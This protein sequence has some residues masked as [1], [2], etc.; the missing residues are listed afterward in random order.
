[1]SIISS[2]IKLSS[3]DKMVA[4]ESLFWV[5]EV[6]FMLWLFPFSF[7]QKRVQKIASYF[8]RSDMKVPMNRIR[9][10][11]HMASRYVP[12]ATCL[13]QALA[14]YILFSKYGY[15]T[16][17]KIGV[18]NEDGVFEAHAWL[19]YGENVVLGESEKDYK[20]ILDIDGGS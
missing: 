19:E 3:Q 11:I 1:M 8:S 14:G 5:M 13:V 10:M 16:L 20:T 6:R 7:V 9:F 18:S 17:I 12:R 4:I 2:F 15:H